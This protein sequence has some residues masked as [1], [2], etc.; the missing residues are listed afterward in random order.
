MA[1]WG[2]A[3]GAASGIL[4]GMFGSHNADKNIDYEKEVN[5]QKQ[6]NFEKTFNYN[7]DYQRNRFKYGM[8]DM[9]NSGIN[10]LMMGTSAGGVASSS[11][12]APSAPNLNAPHDNSAESVS[13]A[14]DTGTKISATSLQSALGKEQVKNAQKTGKQI[15]SATLL[16]T[17]NTAKSMN[18]AEK[19]SLQNDI[20]KAS[21]ALPN[22]AKNT[23]NNAVEA[24]IGKNNMGLLS[25]PEGIK[26]LVTIYGHKVLDLINPPTTFDPNKHIKDD[27]RKTDD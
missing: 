23:L 16:N 1:M 17:S 11:G 7:K 6:A 14:I 9:K 18:E 13:R 27:G 21:S 12:A 3:A 25:S 2:L 24:V 8:E 5:K 20:T 15:D 4:G 19:I 22:A 26:Q 10:P